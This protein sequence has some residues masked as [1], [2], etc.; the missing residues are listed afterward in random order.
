MFVAV[1]V[2]LRVVIAFLFGSATEGGSMTSAH[3]NFWPRFGQGAGFGLTL[4]E[5]AGLVLVAGALPREISSGAAREPMCRAISR[6]AFVSA[7][8]V[9]AMCIPVVLGSIALLSSAGSSALLFDAGP[10][11][12]EPVVFGEA[13]DSEGW[14]AWLNQQDLTA[15]K[16]SALLERDPEFVIPDEYYSQVP[17]L[18]AFEEDI[19]AGIWAA[20]WEGL[21]PLAALGLFA[22]MVSVLFSTGALSSGVALGVVLVFGVIFAPEMGEKAWWIFANWLPGMGHESALSTATRLAEGY[23]DVLPRPEAAWPTAWRGM[24]GGGLISGLLAWFFF[25]RRR[26]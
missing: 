12:T 20:L 16:V 23:T 22:F 25:S 6:A 14:H 7:R 15:A 24:L 5:L 1:V 21:L 2:G 17:I 3:N 13:P 18:I 9:V 26:L 11:V 19:S 10:V 8:L 4:A